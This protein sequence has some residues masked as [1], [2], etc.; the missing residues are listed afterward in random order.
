MEAHIGRHL[1]DRGAD[2]AARSRIDRADW[3]AP[4]DV[5]QDKT[6]CGAA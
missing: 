1:P 2:A 5:V 6:A 4:L 3:N